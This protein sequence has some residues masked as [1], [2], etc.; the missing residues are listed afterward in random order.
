MKIMVGHSLTQGEPEV[1]MQVYILTMTMAD[2]KRAT[3]SKLVHL[4]IKLIKLV[5]QCEWSEAKAA[6]AKILG[7][8]H[9]AREE[10]NQPK[11]KLIASIKIKRQCSAI[12]NSLWLLTSKWA[13]EQATKGL[14]AARDQAAS[15]EDIS[16]KTF[17]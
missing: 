11:M 1:T 13:T 16:I 5:T 6:N 3:K 15:Q 10:L 17:R 4:C 2:L 8:I 14:E 12:I 9:K 7:N